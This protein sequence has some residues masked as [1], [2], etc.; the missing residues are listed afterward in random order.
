[1]D[2]WASTDATLP[3]LFLP[4]RRVDTAVHTPSIMLH[5][6]PHHGGLQRGLYQ[7]NLMTCS[8]WLHS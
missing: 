2:V 4:V 3:L 5:A 1:M 8:A 6:A 7:S